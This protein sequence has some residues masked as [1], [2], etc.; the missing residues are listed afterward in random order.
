MTFA[1]TNLEIFFPSEMNED[2][3]KGSW[4]LW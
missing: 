1:T 3:K 4:R 2:V